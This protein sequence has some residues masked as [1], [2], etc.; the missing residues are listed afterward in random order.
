MKCPRDGAPLVEGV[1]APLPH[2]ACEECSG[3]FFTAEHLARLPQHLESGSSHL[4]KGS[5][6]G[7]GKGASS[8]VTCNCSSAPLME[9]VFVRGVE[10]DCCPEC[11][12]VWL[13]QG[14]LRKLW[15]SAGSGDLLSHSGA[16]SS[17][18][19]D[20]DWVLA[21]GEVLLQFAIHL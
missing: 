15:K 8:T 13:D 17:E 21:L 7:E 10:I 6:T 11:S 16:E 12:S 20:R 14:E 4:R 18:T 19:P 5:G 3:L 9:V 1:V 2:L